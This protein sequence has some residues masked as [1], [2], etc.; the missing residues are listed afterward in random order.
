MLSEL[1]Q[2]PSFINNMAGGALKRFSAA[3]GYNMA[4]SSQEKVSKQLPEYQPKQSRLPVDQS[5]QARSVTKQQTRRTD[6]S[7]IP[8]CDLNART[9]VKITP[10]EDSAQAKESIQ[11][12]KVSKAKSPVT[13]K[14][15]RGKLN[16]RSYHRH[17]TLVERQNNRHKI[18]N[19]IKAGQARRKSWRPDQIL[20]DRWAKMSPK[21]RKELIHKVDCLATTGAIKAYA[22]LSWNLPKLIVKGM[23]LAISGEMPEYAND[24]LKM[25]DLIRD[26]DKL[27]TNPT[28]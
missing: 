2:V 6:S 27:N 15:T 4:C 9:E 17:K 11:P 14:R 5:V 22:W 18:L 3:V 12:V 28:L 21:Q 25:C 20:I 26:L 13:P 7:A 8:E 10:A 19:K 16:A 23:Y 1:A 24:A